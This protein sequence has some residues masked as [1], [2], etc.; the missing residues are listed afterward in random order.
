MKYKTKLKTVYKRRDKKNHTRSL[1]WF[2]L[3][4]ELH[5]VLSYPLRIYYVVK[6]RLQNTHQEYDLEPLK[7]THHSF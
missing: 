6:P 2:T 5:P 3:N 1:Y 7:N 4:Q